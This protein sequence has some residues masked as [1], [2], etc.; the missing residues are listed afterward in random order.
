MPFP[1][2]PNDFNKLALERAAEELANPGHSLDR[3]SSSSDIVPGERVFAASV[4]F[5]GRRNAVLFGYTR[6]HGYAK[7]LTS[8]GEW[9]M[10]QPEVMQRKCAR[11]QCQELATSGPAPRSNNWRYCGG[12]RD[13]INAYAAGGVDI[14]PAA[15]EKAGNTG[16]PLG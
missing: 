15:E 12:C 6:P 4:T 7:I 11:Y 1:R 5:R 16:T 13:K 3:L 2:L 8:E 14:I 10:V 9:L